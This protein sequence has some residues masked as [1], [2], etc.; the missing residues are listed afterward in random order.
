MYYLK[1]MIGEDSVNVALRR[2]LNKFKYKSSPF[3]VSL[4]VIDEFYAA[5]PDSLDYII[6]DLFEDI[7]IFENRC[8]KVD[9]KE[10]DGGKYEITI[11]VSSKKFKSDDLGNETEV[12]V[13]DYIEIGAF[14]KAAD[15]QDYGKTLYR[16]R[17]K[18]NSTENTFTFI[19]DEKPQEAG[20][21]PFL[22]LIDKEPKDN[23][24]NISL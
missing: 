17:V 16:Q 5:T 1:E 15:N 8:E 24:K 14:A 22:L 2:F 21:D 23:L 4:D 9:V 11:D 10:L 18:I 13:N 3:P 20:I 6:K 19:V 12:P 7:T